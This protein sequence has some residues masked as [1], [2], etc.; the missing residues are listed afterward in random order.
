[1]NDLGATALRSTADLV[2]GTPL[3]LL[4][5]PE[6]DRYERPADT[7]YFGI[8]LISFGGEPEWPA[9]DGPRVFVSVHTA[10]QFEQWL[11]LLAPL[12]IRCLARTL[13]GSIRGLSKFEHIRTFDDPPLD[14]E[15][16][17]E[18]CDAILCYGSSNL[19]SLG[20]L[21]GKPI[22]VAASTPDQLMAGLA[23]QELGAGL[24]MS[25]TPDAGTPAML[26]RL[27]GDSALR[28]AAGRFS[29]RYAGWSRDTIPQRLLDAVLA[30]PP[31][32]F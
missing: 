21:K 17:A 5:Y 10:Q 3:A 2:R 32:G 20:L 27:L 31:G 18:S 30:V 22:G 1:M 25:T 4:S 9:G 15:R 7:R 12:K 29:D 24:L 6:L 14:F 13:Y 16:V 28:Q 19:I 26:E 23:V 11:P 8:P